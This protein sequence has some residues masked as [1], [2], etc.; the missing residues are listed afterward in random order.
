MLRLRLTELPWVCRRHPAGTVYFTR[1]A[2]S[3]CTSHL[4]ELGCPLPGKQATTRGTRYT[5]TRDY[6]GTRDTYCSGLG[7]A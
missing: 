6:P 4:S 1:G 3:S 2:V 5:F 7:T